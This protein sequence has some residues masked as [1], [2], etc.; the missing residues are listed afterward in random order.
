MAK[1]SHPTRDKPDFLAERLSFFDMLKRGTQSQPGTKQRKVPAAS[2][3]LSADQPVTSEPEAPVAACIAGEPVLP[4]QDVASWEQAPGALAVSP[5]PVARPNGQQTSQPAAPGSGTAPRPAVQESSARFAG[6]GLPA[7]AVLLEDLKSI[8]NPTKE[9]ASQTSREQTMEEFLRELARLSGTK[10]FQATE[11]DAY[12]EVRSPT[13]A[14][15]SAATGG[16]LS[17]ST[18]FDIDV[19]ALRPM[20]I[21]AQPSCDTCWATVATM[22][23]SWRDKASYTIQDVMN[24]AGPTYRAK[25]DKGEGLAASEKDAFLKT[26]GMTGEAPMCYT[27][28]GLRALL[29]TH[30]PLWATTDEQPGAGFSIHARII[31]GMFGDETVDGTSLRVIDP[32]GGRQYTETFREFAQKFEEVAGTGRL[33]V[34][35]VNF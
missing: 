13:P 10:E 33:W 18:S 34:Q 21:I 22:M 12:F 20:P 30:G 27:V 5:L 24:M 25:F 11:R 4:A 7:D 23:V 32:D 29:E 31:T 14:A 15:S 17:H 1:Q 3:I 26:L 19:T 6:R 16:I 28:S 9:R 8:V 35:I 2:R